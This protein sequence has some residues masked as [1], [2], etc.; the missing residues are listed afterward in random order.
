MVSEGCGTAHSPRETGP[1][2]HMSVSPDAS[3]T[4]V[5]YGGRADIVHA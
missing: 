1:A 4:C 3:S 5:P 2:F